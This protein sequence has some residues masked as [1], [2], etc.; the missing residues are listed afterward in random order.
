MEKVKDFEISK[1]VSADTLVGQM[2]ESV[3]FTAKKP[4]R[5][6]EHPRGNA[7]GTDILTFLSFPACII[8][9]GAQ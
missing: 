8:A 6:C 2:L 5:R 4:R 1:G 7:E 9:T 3:G